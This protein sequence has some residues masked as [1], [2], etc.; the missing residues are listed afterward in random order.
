[1]REIDLSAIADDAPVSWRDNF[2]VVVIPMCK[3]LEFYVKVS[4]IVTLRLSWRST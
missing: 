4:S 3:L 2:G 1:M